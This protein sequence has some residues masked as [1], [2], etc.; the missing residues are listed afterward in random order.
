MAKNE[1]TDGMNIWMT[2]E[3]KLLR[4]RELYEEIISS[5][6]YAERFY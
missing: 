4:R 2:C 3:E 1:R 5:S 6:G